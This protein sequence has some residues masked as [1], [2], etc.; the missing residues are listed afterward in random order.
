M[1]QEKNNI[2]NS[3]KKSG[4]GFTVPKAYFEELED[5]IGQKMDSTGSNPK[6]KT[7]ERSKQKNMFVLDKIGKNH[8]F[9]T[10]DGYFDKLEPKIK[11]LKTTRVVPLKNNYTRI[12]ALSI[13]A[14]ILLFFGISNMNHSQNEKN[15]I[16]F[17]D[18]E[19]INW[20]ESDLV[21]LDSYEIAEI[22]NDIELDKVFY[23]EDELEEYL[24]NVDI[25]HLILEN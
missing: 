23:P 25:E 14:S 3:L 5:R 22:Y 4:P 1:D 6:I 10:P 16:V 20:I 19:Y 13:A 11:R 8:G 17:Q 9:K 18:E 7:E 2:L 15:E 12:L 21:E 24:N